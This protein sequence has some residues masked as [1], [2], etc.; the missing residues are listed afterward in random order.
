MV[1]SLKK[2]FN[3]LRKNVQPIGHYQ[4]LK[5]KVQS[6][7]KNVQLVGHDQLLKTYIFNRLR[8]KIQP[9]QLEKIESQFF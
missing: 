5:T 9:V 8:K 1:N 4:Y 6:F 3:Q 7:E 2:K